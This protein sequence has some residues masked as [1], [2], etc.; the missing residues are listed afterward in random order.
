MRQMSMYIKKLPIQQ[1]KARHNLQMNY[2]TGIC[3][4]EFKP[5]YSDLGQWTCRFTKR[6]KDTEV[7]LGSSTLI[8]LNTVAGL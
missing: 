7:E 1:K 8:L 5:D 6:D 4:I 3:T 2:S